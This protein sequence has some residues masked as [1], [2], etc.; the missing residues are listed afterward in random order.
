VKKVVFL[1]LILVVSFLFVGCSAQNGSN[2]T[3]Q[4]TLRNHSESSP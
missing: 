3:L 2:L 4:F 1:G